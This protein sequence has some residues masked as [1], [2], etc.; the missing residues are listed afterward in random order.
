MEG[1]R[2]EIDQ[3]LEEV[4]VLGKLAERRREEKGL[5]LKFFQWGHVERKV[6]RWGTAGSY[7]PRCPV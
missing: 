2:R 5:W 4:F 7:L 3:R 6:K 1:G